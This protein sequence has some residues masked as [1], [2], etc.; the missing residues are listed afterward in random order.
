MDTSNIAEGPDTPE[1]HENRPVGMTR[2]GASSFKEHVGPSLPHFP[3]LEG[4]VK[5]RKQVRPEPHEVIG[6]EQNH[7]G[8]GVAETCIDHLSHIRCSLAAHPHRPI[9][10]DGMHTDRP[11]K[12]KHRVSRGPVAPVNDE[13]L[14]GYGAA[15]YTS[16]PGSVRPAPRARRQ[17]WRPVAG[18][19]RNRAASLG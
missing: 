14:M 3:A 2:E 19:R 5:V 12:R 10:F 7:Y 15:L 6:C 16:Q 11:Q 17:W 13:H 4:R 9:P 8:S 1:L 18:R